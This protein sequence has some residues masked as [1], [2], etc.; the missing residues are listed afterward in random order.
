[1]SL[2][3][4]AYPGRRRRALSEVSFT[5]PR[6]S[7]VA[8]VGPSGAGKTTVASLFLRFWDPDE[9]TVRLDGHDLREYRLDDL[10]QRVALVAQD[11]YLFNDTLRNNVLLARPEASPADLA[12]A[13]EQ[14]VLTE[15]VA[16]LPDGLDTVVGERGAQ[17]SGGQRQRVAIARAFLKDAPILILDEPTSGLDPLGQRAF[18]QFLLEQAGR[19][20]TV[21]MSSHILSE[22]EQW[23]SRV[24]IIREGRIVRLGG[25]AEV[26]DIKRYE[27]TITF[28]DPVPA[29][30]FERVEGVEA[31]ESTGGGLGVRLTMQGPA[32]AVVKA[33]AQH[34]VLSLSSH[35]PSLEDTFLRYYEADGK[36]AREATSVVR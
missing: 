4:F 36:P 10:R 8:L 15:F 28:A 14:A 11:T 30:A 33:A 13:V 21:F 23:C 19:G 22:V 35:E 29:D 25:V 27:I 32:D 9:G 2:V 6:G 1:M 3:S 7:T 17:L 24:G 12:A 31:V 34:R 16:G 18:N 26:K 20:M 5:V